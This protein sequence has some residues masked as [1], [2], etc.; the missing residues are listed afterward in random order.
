MASLVPL[1]T[2]STPRVFEV[3]PVKAWRWVTW[4]RSS[5]MSCC[6]DGQDLALTQL[7][8][9]VRS[10]AH[11]AR[12]LT[13]LGHFHWPNITFWVA[14]ELSLAIFTQQHHQVWPYLATFGIR[15]WISAQITFTQP[16]NIVAKN[17]YLTQNGAFD[18]KLV[19]LLNWNMEEIALPWGS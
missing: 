5:N 4:Y 3:K 7:V 9:Q 2:H 12:G 8:F 15:H 16:G 19:D 14:T 17:D 11:F 10:P 13:E 18:L 1:A 6:G